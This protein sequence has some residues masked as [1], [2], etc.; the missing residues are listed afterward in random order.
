MLKQLHISN[1]ALIDQTE[2]LFPEGLTVITGETGAGKSILLGALG[3]VLGDRADLS[4]LGD[5]TKKCVIEATFDISGHE[6]KELFEN[7]ELEFAN[8]TIIRREIN[9]D[10]RSRAFVNDSP[11][12]LQAIKSLAEKLIDVHS[13][14]ETLLL[15][16]ASFR[17]DV[18]DSFAGIRNLRDE[19]NRTYK[20]FCNLR[21]ELKELQNEEQHFIKERDFLQFQY[22]ELEQA[23]IKTGELQELEQESAQ[24]ENAETIK[25]NLFQVYNA[26][27][28]GELSVLSQITQV[29][30]WLS[31]LNKY[32][33]EF[34]TLSERINS[35]LIEL[36]DIASEAQDLGEAAN[37]DPLRL[38][39]V[40]SKIDLLNR[41]FKKHGVTS[42]EGLM[43]VLHETGV[44]LES[45]GN[46]EE[47]IARVSKELS[48]AQDRVLKLA[49]DLSEKRKKKIP[50]FEKNISTMLAD[51]SMPNARFEIELIQNK[52]PGPFGTDELKFLFSANKGAELKE[53]HKTASGGELNR[54]M[55]CI[56]SQ[57]AKSAGLATIIF[58]EIDTGVSGDVAFRIGKILADMGKRMQVISITHLPQIAGKGNSHLFVFKEDLDKRTVSRIKPLSTDER[59]KEIAKMLSS[60][61]PSAAALKN[62]KEL[63]SSD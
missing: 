56:K 3:L 31:G 6:L 10:G 41:L 44:K 24:L 57:T 9:P 21:T 30:N 18:L 5:K 2:I 55:L 52:E 49:A 42:E 54:L 38:E 40:N 37:T 27:L 43:R 23:Q 45:I 32:G 51:L 17:F 28:E 14:H 48:L 25:G 62:A 1:Y 33:A 63:L 22:N 13:Q 8:Q 60:G 36:K 34:N 53:L 50:D 26:L 19:Y 29:K 7:A 59:V 11:A 61:T 58:D 39:T 15:N 20:D 4:A 16:S 35:L 47:R 46:V 12:N